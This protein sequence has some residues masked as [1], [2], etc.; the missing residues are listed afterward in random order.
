MYYVLLNASYFY[1]E[2][3][4]AYGPRQMMAGLPFL[5]LGLA[6]LWDAWRPA[7]RA[8]LVAGWIWGAALTLVAVSTTPQP[9]ATFKAPVRELLWPAFR[10]GDLS[11][12]P[13]TFVHNSADVEPAARRAADRT[14]RG[15]SARS[16]ACT[17]WRACCRWRSSGSS[18]RALLLRDCDRRDAALT[19]RSSSATA[20]PTCASSTRPARRRPTPR[21][22]RS[23]PARAC[24]CTR[25]STRGCRARGVELRDELI[26]EARRWFGTLPIERVAGVALPFP[27]AAFDVV[28]SFD[29]FEH[30]PDSDAHLREVGRV[31]RPG[32]TYL[33]Q[34]PNKW[35]NVVFETIRWR[36]FTRFREDHCSLHTLAELTAPAARARL[37][38]A[39]V[40]RA[41]RQRVFP[42]E[43][44]P[45]PRTGRARWRCAIVNP[46]R[47]PLAWRTNLYVRG[48]KRRSG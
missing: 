1:W 23:A 34:T 6:P 3:G 33:I 32:G 24:C 35:T 47:L 14:R 17:A 37:R 20:K 11:L 43:G 18:R 29:V 44:A 25:C 45:L 8:L 46:D 13:Q 42:G 38:R 39:C 30:I 2:G 27:D 12:N 48:T 22:S 28:M 5:A 40:R 36:S 7:A 21:S 16:R 31:L 4:W 10:D 19:A 41:G 15:T 9:P 26:A